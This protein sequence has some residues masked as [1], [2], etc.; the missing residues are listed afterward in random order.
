MSKSARRIASLRAGAKKVFRNRRRVTT[1]RRVARTVAPPV[2]SPAAHPS[3][4]VP[5]T[6]FLQMVTLAMVIMCVV[7]IGLSRRPSPLEAASVTSQPSD[8]A[9]VPQPV[10]VALAPAPTA[11]PAAV[12][13]VVPSRAVS[14]SA[15]KAAALNAEKARIAEAP[16][17]AAAVAAIDEALGHEDSLTSL[18]A[19]ES[20]SVVPPAAS[21]DPVPAGT[22]TVTGCLESSGKNQ[23][24]LTN[25]DGA[26]V[27]KS[28]SWR[29]GFLTKRATSVTLVAA[30]DP[31]ALQTQVGQRIAASG[32]LT[33][34]ELRVA[35]V[36]VLG[37]RCD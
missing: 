10:A 28:R 32:Q 20:T 25:T 12:A 19:P 29:S 2:E 36:Q 11:A 4:A 34:H 22:V 6:L 13:T 18:V 21:V 30:P 8:V 14:T 7:A 16:S 5:Q 33:N 26:E 24:R 1:T 27:P 37:A 9:T 3:A 31:Y 35:S 17:P 23:F 15:A